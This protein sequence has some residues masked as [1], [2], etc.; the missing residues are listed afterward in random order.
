[1]NLANIA[2][3]RH[4]SSV[5]TIKAKQWE[6]GS[7]FKTKEAKYRAKSAVLG[8]PGRRSGKEVLVFKAQAILSGIVTDTLEE[9]GFHE[10]MVWS[11]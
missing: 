2:L 7:E 6:Y 1:M 5:D 4:Q 3:D 10:S 9:D 11:R 8:E